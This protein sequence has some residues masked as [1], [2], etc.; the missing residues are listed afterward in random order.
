MYIFFLIVLVTVRDKQI[1][2]RLKELYLVNWFNTYT[3]PEV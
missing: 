2:L 1:T 3:T